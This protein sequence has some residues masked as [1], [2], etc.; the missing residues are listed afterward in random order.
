MNIPFSLP[1]IDQP[2]IDEMIHTLTVTGW[3]TSGP[4]VRALED[5]IGKFI[6]NRNTLCV[7][8]WTSGAMLVLHWFGV[9]P[10]DEVIVPSYTYCATAMC[11]MNLGAKPVMVDV[12]DDFTI[13]P[14]KL[15]S[16]ITEKTKAIILW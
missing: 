4:K 13:D 5:E 16:A 3:L 1:V 9:G 2:V 10:G 15:E 12:K 14:E 8:S 7:N 6:G 11:A